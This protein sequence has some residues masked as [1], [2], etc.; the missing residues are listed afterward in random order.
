MSS[1]HAEKTNPYSRTQRRTAAPH[2]AAGRPQQEPRNPYASSG[3]ARKRSGMSG[4]GKIALIAVGAV[5]L[6]V[7]AVFAG[8]GA[9]AAGLD[10]IYPNVTVEGVDLGGLTVQQ[11]QEKLE[12]AGY[13]ES[14]EQAVS[15]KITEKVSIVVTLAD[16]GLVPDGAAEAA[17]NAYSYGRSGGFIG[18]TVAY[19]RSVG[20]TT[21]VSAR[22]D[23]AFDEM[24]VRAIIAEAASKVNA[25]LSENAYK[26]TE[27]T[28]EITKGASAIL[29]DEDEI[30]DLIHQAFKNRNYTEL[31][32]DFEKTD[33][34]PIDLAAIHKT[35]TTEMKNSEYDKT[36]GKGTQDVRGVTFDLTKAKNMYNAAADG[37]TISVDLIITEPEVTKEQL[38]A[39]LFRDVLGEKMTTMYTS[40]YARLN[41]IKLA[42]EAFNGLILNPG[43]EFSFNGVV[44]ERTA[45]KGYQGAAAYVGG[46]TVTEIGGGICQ[47]ASTLY[48]CT[49]LADLEIVE[50]YNHMYA[51]SYL[52]LG[53]D[54]TVNWGTVDFRFKNNRDYPIKLV[55]YVSNA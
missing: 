7:V 16:A 20:N 21:D 6:F 8:I 35:V 29:L 53:T 24:A 41:N 32:Y 30:Y 47:S 17:E 37:E 26:L 4:G 22:S 54:A 14:G 15:L 39:S 25:E 12:T 36:T 13:G 34:K 46:K 42:S 1:K 23:S 44:G 10:T 33:P 43:E 45:A 27:T 11:A 51:I 40:S 31:E 49:L 5:L 52:P 2:S 48:Y 19:I 3:G 38:E 50:R 28:I 55:A 9:F 18:N